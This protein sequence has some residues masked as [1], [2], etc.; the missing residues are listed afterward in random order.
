[1]NR[2]EENEGGDNEDQDDGQILPEVKE[3]GGPGSPEFL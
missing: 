1:V 3:I 2:L